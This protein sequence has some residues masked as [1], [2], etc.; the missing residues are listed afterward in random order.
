M[1]KFEIKKIF[2]KSINKAALLIIVVVLVAVSI[3]TINSVSYTDEE[4]NTIKGLVAARELR[5]KKN[6]W[7]GYVTEDVLKKVIQENTKI[8]SSEEALSDDIQ[9]QNKAYAK[10]QEFS[11]IRELINMSMSGF[12]EY[13]YF[14]A[15]RVCTKEAGIVYDKR[16]SSLKEWLAMSGDSFTEGQKDFLIGQYEK[17][18]TPFYYEYIGGWDTMMPYLTI[19][20]LILAL[21]IGFLSAGIFSSEFQLKAESI[22]FSAKLG[23]NKAIQTKIG[24]G[25][26]V[27]TAV[28]FFFTFL[29]T[30][31]VLLALGADG[32]NCP[33]QFEMWKSFYNIT[34]FQWYLL[35]VIGGYVG[36][37]F[38]SLLAMAVSAKTHS[39]A[40][41]VVI[42]FIVLC[43]I[44]VLSNVVPLPDKIYALFPNQLL[45][46]T[47]TVKDFSLYTI[48]GKVMGVINLIIPA[49]AMVS[50]ILILLLY[51]VYQRAEVK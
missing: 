3:F 19:F 51:V 20:I 30:V 29:F 8:N 48:G 1:L 37:L 45:Y 21:V 32:A 39:T 43:A 31:I 34:F 14:Y 40:I 46:I 28:Y 7:S 44:P 18:K 5:E 23:R 47:E 22:F 33:I 2:S 36:T 26:L 9:E 24:A 10:T 42:P 41:A 38:S 49:Y 12:G 50:V 11:D 13:D 17:L 16:I 15:D 25:I 35:V 27:V 6:R 4:G